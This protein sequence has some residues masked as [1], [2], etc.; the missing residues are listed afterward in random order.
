MSTESTQLLRMLGSGVR[1]AG[2]PE[3]A[4]ASKPGTGQIEGAGFADLLKQA[5]QGKLSSHRPVTIEKNAGVDLTDADK[6]ALC[7][8]ADRAE[9]AGLRKALVYLDDKALVLDVQSRSITGRADLKSGVLTGID[10]VLKASSHPA[11]AGDLGTI[12]PMPRVDPSSL[13]LL[14]HLGK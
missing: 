8:A 12:L 6:V 2:I 4:S 10:G 13:S 7:D 3:S 1:P 14:K 11:G 5:E 9:A